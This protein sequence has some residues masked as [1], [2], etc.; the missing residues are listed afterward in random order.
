MFVCIKA[1]RWAGIRAYLS[2]LN[3]ILVNHARNLHAAPRRQ[4]RDQTRVLHISIHDAGLA[5]LEAMNNGRAVLHAA[6]D[7][8]RRLFA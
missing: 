6:S 2:R 5:R 4:V 8:E 7:L 1:A 3:S